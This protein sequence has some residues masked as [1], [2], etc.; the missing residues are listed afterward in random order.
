MNAAVIEKLAVSACK[1]PTDQPESDGT[2]EWDST[3]IVLVEAEADGKH[4]LGYMSPRRA[5]RS[6][7]R[8]IYLS[9]PTA[10]SLANR[11]WS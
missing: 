11:R 1:I 3:T 2:Y 4:S 8:R 5:R 9:T 6:A 7:T 10:L